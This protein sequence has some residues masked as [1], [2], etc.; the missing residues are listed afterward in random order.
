MREERGRSQHV[1]RQNLRPE[2]LDRF[3]FG[4]ETVAADVEMKA[5]VGRGAGNSADIN[6]VGLEHDHVDLILGKE[7]SGGQSRRAGAY[8]RDSLFSLIR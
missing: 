1:V 2:I 8:N 4:K 5:F 6:R 3:R 7:I